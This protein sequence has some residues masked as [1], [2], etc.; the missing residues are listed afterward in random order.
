MTHF[1][2]HFRRNGFRASCSKPSGRRSHLRLALKSTKPTRSQRLEKY[3]IYRIVSSRKS[4][5]RLTAK[6]FSVKRAGRKRPQRLSAVNCST[7]LH[8]HENS[9][10]IS[11]ENSVCGSSEPF[12]KR[13][14][15]T[16]LLFV[17]LGLSLV[18]HA[19]GDAPG[20]TSTSGT[21]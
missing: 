12:T 7:Y 15:V 17:A 8:F 11:H 20:C 9:V 1:F 18:L 5:L 19:G 6:P 2:A 16:R 3:K 21:P 10:C 14:C 13:L 4:C